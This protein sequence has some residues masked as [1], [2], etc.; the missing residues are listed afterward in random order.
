MSTYWGFRCLSACDHPDGPE[1]EC[2]YNHGE[3]GLRNAVLLKGPGLTAYVD[4][5]YGQLPPELCWLAEHPACEVVVANEY[6]DV[7]TREML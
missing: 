6:G 7:S 5:I 4:S 1:S 3:V 2:W